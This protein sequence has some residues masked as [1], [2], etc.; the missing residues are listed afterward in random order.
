MHVFRARKFLESVGFPWSSAAAGCTKRG[1]R[2]HGRRCVLIEPLEQRQLLAYINWINRGGPIAGDTDRFDAAYGDKAAE[3]R[4]IVDVAIADWS[5]VIQNFNYADR[6]HPN[7][8]QI[9][10]SAGADFGSGP[11]GVTSAILTDAEDKPYRASIVLNT[12]ANINYF[13]PETFQGAGAFTSATDYAGSY[14]SSPT[15][16]PPIDF[17]TTVLHEIGHAVGLDVGET[18]LAISQFLTPVAGSATLFNFQAGPA[19][20]PTTAQFTSEGGGHLVGVEDL[21]NQFQPDRRRRLITPL[22]ARILRDAYGYTIWEPT[23]ALPKIGEL[24]IYSEQFCNYFHDPGVDEDGNELGCIAQPLNVAPTVDAIGDQNVNEG[25]LLSFKAEARSPNPGI[26]FIF[27]LAPGA[28]AGAS[29]D[30]QTGLFT[31][32]PTDGA[33]SQ[34]ITVR[35]GD[36]SP[37]FGSQTFTVTVNNAAPSASLSGPT[38]G[39]RGQPRSFTLGATDPGSVDDASGFAYS[40]DWGDGAT[41]QIPASANNGAGVTLDH[42]FAQNGTYTVHLLATDKDGAPSAEVTGTITIGSVGL[43]SDSYGGTAGTALVVGGDVGRDKITLSAARGGTI[44]VLLNGISQGLFGPTTRVLVFGQDGNDDINVA[45]GIT[46][47][48]FLYGGAGNDR[49][50]GGGGD[51]VLVGAGGDDQLTGG[52]GRNVM[53]G[54]Q[55]RDALSGGGNSDLL[56]AGSSAFDANDPALSA[57]LAE[58]SSPR[59]YSTRVANLRGTG[60]GP[61]LNGTFYLQPTGTPT[62]FDDQAADLLT[63]GAGQDWFFANTDEDAINDRAAS[64]L[65]DSIT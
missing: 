50:Q 44:Q 34:S 41:Q 10:L 5:Y 39:V 4:Q 7:E 46:L 59:D 35:A 64:E 12:L 43:Q 57:I 56:I 51:N 27:S 3:A 52:R 14:A 55:G 17:Y 23:S 26:P 15:F 60:S 30:S 32:T 22:D 54:G 61:R 63:A 47:P 16:R 2:G 21:M 53:I 48:A 18:D 40:I 8:L 65:L 31:W 9:H 13:I 42:V 20:D 38:I 58:W 6:S 1:P 33:A 24:P 28:P 25:S 37:T 62:V 49:L 29:I 19:S 36:G 11:Y 45:G